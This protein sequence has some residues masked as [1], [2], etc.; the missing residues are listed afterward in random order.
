[1]IIL[2][3]RLEIKIK[4][5]NSGIV[6]LQELGKMCQRC[7]AIVRTF[8]VYFFYRTFA[9]S[10]YVRSQNAQPMLCCFNLNVLFSV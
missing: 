3:D 7:F 8:A 2:P 9:A 1:M 5:Q 10:D 4:L 6:A